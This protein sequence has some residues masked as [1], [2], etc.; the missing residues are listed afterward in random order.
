MLSDPLLVGLLSLMGCQ[1]LKLCQVC[2]RQVL[3]PLSCLSGLCS[4]CLFTSHYL[5]GPA[6][7]LYGVCAL[8]N[9]GTLIS[10]LG[11]EGWATPSD[12]YLGKCSRCLEQSHSISRMDPP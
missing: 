6:D 4:L 8:L 9:V 10:S 3:Y 11:E 5:Y 12:A 1:D 7:K 2:A